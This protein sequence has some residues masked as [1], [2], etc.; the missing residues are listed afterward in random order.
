MWPFL[1]HLKKQ[2]TLVLLVKGFPLGELGGPNPEKSMETFSPRGFDGLVRRRVRA[3]FVW[4]DSASWNGSQLAGKN[5]NAAKRCQVR[6]SSQAL[7][8]RE[9]YLMRPD[10]PDALK[11]RPVL[12]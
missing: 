10:G 1:S 8:R 6:G 9:I 12:P 11:S 2:P 4:S 3:G 5:C 7:R